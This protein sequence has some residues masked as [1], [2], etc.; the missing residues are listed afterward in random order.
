MLPALI[1]VE[2]AIIIFYLK[3]RMLNEKL[4]SYFDIIKNREKIRKKYLEIQKN[5]IVDDE[6]IIKNF[7]NEI[8]VPS[9]VTNKESNKL[10]NNFIGNLSRLVKHFV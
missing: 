5:R 8:Y 2:I 1:L 10:F 3:K 9:Q 7:S 4:K 6:E